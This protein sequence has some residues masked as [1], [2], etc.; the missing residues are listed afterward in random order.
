[1]QSAGLVDGF[2]LVV[3]TDWASLSAGGLQARVTLTFKV[4]ATEVDEVD[5]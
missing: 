5:A 1:L 2:L 4:P 3:Y